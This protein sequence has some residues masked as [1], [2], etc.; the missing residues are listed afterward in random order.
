VANDT[1]D[2]LTSV[3]DLHMCLHRRQRRL[4][5]AGEG[6]EVAGE[7]PHELEGGVGVRRDLFDRGDRWRATEARHH[8]HCSDMAE[9]HLACEH[10]LGLTSG[11]EAPDHREGG[12]ELFLEQQVISERV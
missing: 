10:G 4:S 8:L 5:H 3:I 12:V 2:R 6:R 11:P 9:R 7:S 1:H